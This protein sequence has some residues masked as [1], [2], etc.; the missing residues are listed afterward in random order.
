M[1]RNN[2]PLRG[3]HKEGPGSIRAGGFNQP[4][5]LVSKSSKIG[6]HRLSDFY[7]FFAAKCHFLPLWGSLGQSERIVSIWQKVLGIKEF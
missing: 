7:H 1:T 6:Y 4:F 2:V 3:S 5:K